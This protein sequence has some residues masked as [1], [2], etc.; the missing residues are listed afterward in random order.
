MRL[1]VLLLLLILPLAGC[2][3][4]FDDAGVIENRLRIHAVDVSAPEVRSGSVTLLV[5]TTLTN[6]MGPAEDV[7]VAVRAFD[8]GTGLR[9]DVGEQEV[10]RIGSETTMTVE[11]PMRLDRATGYRL[12]VAI[13]QQDL[14]IQEHTLRISNVDALEPNVFETGLRIAGMDFEV[15]SLQREENQTTQVQIDAATYLT[16]EG[17]GPSRPLELQL[18]A[19]EVSTGLLA[20]SHRTPVDAIAVEETVP[21]SVT[22][23]VPDGYNYVVEAVL[24][25]DQII[26]GRGQGNVQLLPTFEKPADTDIVVEQPNVEDFVGG[27]RAEDSADGDFGDQATPG[28]GLIAVLAMLTLL[29]FITRR[30]NP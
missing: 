17:T 19:R 8:S 21:V 6:R 25:D 5:N 2:L 18:K 12:V 14:L 28:P 4:D 13:F 26:V 11:V 22:L 9:L 24:W 27:G 3:N 30:R 20:D 1:W 15:A 29:V 16:N 10:A 23:S 7:L